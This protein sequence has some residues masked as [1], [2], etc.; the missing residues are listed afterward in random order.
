MTVRFLALSALVA[1]LT[2]PF[3]ATPAQAAGDSYPYRADTTQSSDPW[4]FTKRQCVS[5]AAWQLKQAGHA[6]S[7]EGNRWGDAN[8][9]D[10]AARA[11][12]VRLGVTPV[13]G[14]VAQWNANETSKYYPGKGRTGYVQAG[15][16]GHVAVV[17]QT[18]A[19]KSAIV[20]QYN[21]SGNRSY[22]TM[23][24]KAPRYLYFR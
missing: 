17:L 14:A 24:V 6:I 11:N 16:Y 8:H 12:G 22:S 15:G 3:L 1:A 4:G 23:H 10:E 9:W 19:D 21:M 20:G 13:V 2:S 18:F 7:N 5:F